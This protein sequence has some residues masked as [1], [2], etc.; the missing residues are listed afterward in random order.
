MIKIHTYHPLDTKNYV[1][2]VYYDCFLVESQCAI[3][4][5]YD[6]VDQLFY[7]FSVQ[8]YIFTEIAVMPAWVPY[9]T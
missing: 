7:I 9:G 3:L 6:K 4:N 5:V 8:I 1:M 2:Y